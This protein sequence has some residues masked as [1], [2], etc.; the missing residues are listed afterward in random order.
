AND[1]Y[2]GRIDAPRAL[3]QDGYWDIQNAWFNMEQQGPQHRDDYHLPTTLT[4][5]KIQESMSP[6]NT[7]SFWQLPGFIR[8]LKTI[9]LP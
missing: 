9:G 4:F 3:L 5:G 7:I 1:H 2:L 8:A 6:P